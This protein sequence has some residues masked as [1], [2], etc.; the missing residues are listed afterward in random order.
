MPL[1]VC[2]ACYGEGKFDCL[3]C[4]GTGEI[5]VGFLKRIKRCDRCN[6]TGFVIYGDCKG[7]GRKF[8]YML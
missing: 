7:E 5:K 2:K 4:K 1:S 3:K 8:R 6:G